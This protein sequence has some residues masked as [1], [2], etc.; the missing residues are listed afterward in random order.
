MTNATVELAPHDND[1]AKQS[2]EYLE[3]MDAAFYAALSRARQR[4]EIGERLNLHDYARYL[5]TS[6]QG[7]AVV[8]KVTRDSRVLHGVVRAVMSALAM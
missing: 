6:V 2:R 7:L 3:Q 1:A 5:T 8:A 4:G